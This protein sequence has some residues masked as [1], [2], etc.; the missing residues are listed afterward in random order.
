MHR[1]L[2]DNGLASAGRGAD[3]YP[4]TCLE[5]FACVALEGVKLEGQGA[6]ELIEA[7]EGDPPA[8][9]CVRLGGRVGHR[10]RLGDDGERS[11][12]AVH[13]HRQGA[14]RFTVGVDRPARVAV[15]AY[16]FGA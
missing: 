11:R 13:S 1:E 15:D 12:F 10:P 7:R 3:Q 16:G 5:R 8:G 9:R 6:G 14:L 2:P 4:M